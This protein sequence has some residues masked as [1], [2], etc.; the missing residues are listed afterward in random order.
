MVWTQL[1]VIAKKTFQVL[2]CSCR[3]VISLDYVISDF[4]TY[5]LKHLA[6]IYSLSDYILS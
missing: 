3:K 2:L 4:S 5:V 1:V 6:L